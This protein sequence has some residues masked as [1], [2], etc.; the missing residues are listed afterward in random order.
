MEEII[1]GGYTIEEL[2]K[3]QKAVQKDASKH[4]A[5]FQSKAETAMHEIIAHAKSVEDSD[6]EDAQIDSALV[7][8][9]AKVADESLRMVE[10]IAGISGVEYYLLYSEDWGDNG[11]VWSNLLEEAGVENEYDSTTSLGK[12]FGILEDME[13]QSRNWHSS[14]C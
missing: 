4:M 9:L 2:K 1:I 8:S 13:Y 10:L 6:D 7:E 12:L 3:V 5:D 14:S 11:D